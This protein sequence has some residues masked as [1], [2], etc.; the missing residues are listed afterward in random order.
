MDRKTGN[1]ILNRAVQGTITPEQSKMIRAVVWDLIP[2]DSFRSGQWKYPYSDRLALVVNAVQSIPETKS[3]L[4]SVVETRSVVTIADAQAAFHE[5]FSAGD[6]GIILKDPTGIWENKRAKHQIKFK[7]ELECDLLCVGYQL[8]SGKYSG[9]LGALVLQS[10]DAKVNVSVGTGFS[11]SMRS[12]LTEKDVL[13]KIVSVKYNARI[14]SKARGETD[15]LFLPVFL[16]I[17][18]D[19]TEADSSDSVA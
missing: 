13:G 4:V 11:D 3:Y 7:G 16:E 6:E 17:R 15:S 18:E 8:G 5:Y 9:M 2:I 19:K 10:S 1:G 14:Q 12:S